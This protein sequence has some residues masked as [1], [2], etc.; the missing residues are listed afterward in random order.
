MTGDSVGAWDPDRLAQVFSNL[1]GNA[2]QHGV[3][4]GGVKV[5]IDGSAPERVR[6]AVHNQG[7]IPPH[8]FP[9]VFEPMSG[10]ETRR[11]GSHGL[12]LGL[13]ITEQVARAHGGAVSVE[14][15]EELGTTFTV[16]LPRTGRPDPR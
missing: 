11:S 10:A 16:W 6:V 15:T 13:F 14:S 2:V 3:A 9:R 1:L 7:C 5:H 12:G 8:L 4:A